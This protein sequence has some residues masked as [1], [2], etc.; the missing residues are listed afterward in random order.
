MASNIQSESFI[1][2]NYVA[3]KFVYDIVAQGYDS[4]DNIQIIF[5]RLSR[6]HF[7]LDHNTRCS[8]SL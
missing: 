8:L 6:V 7:G 1:Q 2:S 3:L 5:L 4:T